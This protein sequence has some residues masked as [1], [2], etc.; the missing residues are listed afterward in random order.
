M[1]SKIPKASNPK[2]LDPF[3]KPSNTAFLS[4]STPQYP[5]PYEDS[6]VKFQGYAKYWNGKEYELKKQTRYHNSLSVQSEHTITEDN[7]PNYLFIT[8]IL[9]MPDSLGAFTLQL[10]DDDRLVLAMPS[11]ATSTDMIINIHLNQP[12]RFNGEHRYWICVAGGGVNYLYITY[13]GYTEEK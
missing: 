2:L 4:Q 1:S 10:Y 5:P 13:W 6:G 7:P 11:G 3:G 12:I 8:D 9:I